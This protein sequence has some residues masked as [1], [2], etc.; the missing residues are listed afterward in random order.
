M[1]LLVIR[2]GQSEADILKR[3]EGRADFPLTLLGK[4]QALLM[5]EWVKELYIPD[6]ILSS[7][8][9][10]ASK[11]AQ[12]LSNKTDVE[13]QY[14]T[15]LMEFNNGL[16]AGLTKEEADAKYPPQKDKKPHER[17]YEQETLIEFRLRAET[18]LSKIIY[19]YPFDK[20][21]AIISHGGMI[22][23]LFK[24][25]LKLPVNCDVSISTADTG[26]HLWKVDEDKRHIVF[27]NSTKHLINT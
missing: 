16:I 24:S 1:E 7:T 9:I 12:I 27:L 13:V 8:L 5:A 26:I 17:F 18:I 4:Q 11:T 23:M 21:I 15:D 22:N 25:F 20:R 19:E 14:Y 6:Y 2:H 3:I 10:R